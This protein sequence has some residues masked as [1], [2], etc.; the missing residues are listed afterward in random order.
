MK[1]IFIIVLITALIPCCKVKPKI[2][3]EYEKPHENKLKEEIKKY[4]VDFNSNIFL[5][6]GFINTDNIIANSVSQ[7]KLTS[8]QNKNWPF[9]FDFSFDSTAIPIYCIKKANLYYLIIAFYSNWNDSYSGP[10]TNSNFLF[11]YD[12][13][14]NFKDLV[15]L[16]D[17][18]YFQGKYELKTNSNFFKHFGSNGFSEIKI[19]KNEI[20]C[21]TTSL[22]IWDNNELI[23]NRSAAF[24]VNSNGMIKEIPTGNSSKE[25]YYCKDGKVNSEYNSTIKSF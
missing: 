24:S 5:Q 18:I 6:G 16:P 3:Y 19:S 13:S 14:G 21:N 1:F 7:F 23:Y 9:P 20:F 11:T 15:K 25:S 2:Y 10:S 17:F 8:T 4:K 22:K 12:F